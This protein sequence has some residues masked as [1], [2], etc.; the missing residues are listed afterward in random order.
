MVDPA[1]RAAFERA[2][3]DAARADSLAE[4]CARKNLRSLA[5]YGDLIEE[6]WTALRQEANLSMGEKHRVQKELAAAI[7]SASRENASLTAEATGQPDKLGPLVNIPSWLLCGV[8]RNPYIHPPKP[9]RK[10]VPVWELTE[11]CR[12]GDIFLFSTVDLGAKWIQRFTRSKWNHVAMVVRPSPSKTCAGAWRLQSRR[13][14][15]AAQAGVPS[16]HAT[17]PS[18]SSWAR[19]PPARRYLVEWGGGLIVQPIVDRLRD[20]HD[21]GARR[22]S[23]R[24]LNLPSVD[25]LFIESRLEMFFFKVL[26]DKTRVDNEV[27]PLENVVPH[28]LYR[29]MWSEDDVVDDLDTLFCSNVRQ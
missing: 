2:L 24:Q 18:T 9:P 5:V 19:P 11:M 13:W 22:I 25:R 12:T 6:D 7:V 29:S 26:T 16:G 15:L 10:K 3:E 17:P 1:V 27:F 8:N 14:C 21:V 28:A 23:L 20:Y 4:L